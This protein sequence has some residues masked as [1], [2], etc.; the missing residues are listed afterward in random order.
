MAKFKPL[1]PL[2]ELQKAFDYNCDTGL[3]KWRKTLSNRALK[4]TV[5]GS[6][7][8]GYVVIRYNNVLYRAHRLA[9]YF[10]TGVDPA[11]MT[12]D[13]KDGNRSNN[14]INNLRLATYKDQQGNRPKPVNNTSGRVGTY[15]DKRRNKWIARLSKKFI[16]S[17]PTKEEAATAYEEAA[18][19]YFGEFRRKQA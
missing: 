16:G 3:F 13:H 7:R 4:G 6:L 5:A 1:P 19:V 9:Y 17:F 8:D 18:K 2:A 15:F 14:A 12:V 10:Y 11:D